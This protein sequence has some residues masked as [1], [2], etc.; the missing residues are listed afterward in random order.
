MTIAV[1]Q[2]LRTFS[3]LETKTKKENKIKI[4]RYVKNEYQPTLFFYGSTLKNSVEINYWHLGTYY[5][6]T[7][8]KTCYKPIGSTTENISTYFLLYINKFS[9]EAVQKATC[10]YVSKPVYDYFR[11][12]EFKMLY[13]DL[14][15]ETM[16]KESLIYNKILARIRFPMT[17]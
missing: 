9:Y 15:F 4:F 5:F 13:S 1:S 8:K 11:S 7:N 6:N 12:N 10:N 17:F 16:D 14:Y 2:L 3:N